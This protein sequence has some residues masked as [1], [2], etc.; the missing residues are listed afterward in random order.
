MRQNFH[1]FQQLPPAQRQ[2]LRERW[3]NATPAQRREMVDH[4]RAQHPP[5]P[6][7]AERPAQRH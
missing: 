3:R 4:A 1:R 7:R 6:P 2:M 5:H